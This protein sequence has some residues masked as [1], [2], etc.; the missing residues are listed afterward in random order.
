M[1]MATQDPDEF[2]RR[3]LQEIVDRAE[4]LRVQKGMENLGEERQVDELEAMLD[5]AQ[6]ALAAIDAR[7]EERRMAGWLE[8]MN[9]GHT[10]LLRAINNNTKATNALLRTSEARLAE[11]ESSVLLKSDGAL[12]ASQDVLD[13]AEYL[14]QVL[15]TGAR[16]TEARGPLL[17][18]A[19]SAPIEPSVKVLVDEIGSILDGDLVALQPPVYEEE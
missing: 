14:Y 19:P 3:Y 13:E 7:Q 6:K 5:Q 8:A 12:R 2:L 1:S 16:G 10:T 15:A 18:D 11:L 9:A 4:R 17:K